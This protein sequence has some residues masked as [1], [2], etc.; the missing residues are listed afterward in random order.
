MHDMISL[1]SGWIF[2]FSSQPNCFPSED[3]SLSKIGGGGV[4]EL[5]GYF[6]YASYFIAG[7]GSKSTTRPSCFV[8]LLGDKFIFLSNFPV[9]SDRIQI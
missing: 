2:R 4:K 5:I 3:E 8:L 7:E 1:A 6:A 9:A